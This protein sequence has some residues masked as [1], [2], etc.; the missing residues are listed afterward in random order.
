MRWQRWC[1]S[2]CW[3]SP[4]RRPTS[5]APSQHVTPSAARPR[6]VT[7]PG[8]AVPSGGLRASPAGREGSAVPA[9]DHSCMAPHQLVRASLR[10]RAPP[11]HPRTHVQPCSRGESAPPG[12]RGPTGSAE[13]GT[14]APGRPLPAA[15]GPGVFWLLNQNDPAASGTLRGPVLTPPPPAI[16]VNTGWTRTKAAP[17][18]PSKCTATSQP[19]GPRASSPTRSP[20]G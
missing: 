9:A 12:W 6:R 11:L 17:G 2:G 7:G 1:G 5:R 3:S 15:H 19:E 18:T 13:R 14:H 10:F 4:Y 16:Q 8:S 20:R